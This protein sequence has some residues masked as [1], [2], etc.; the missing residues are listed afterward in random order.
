MFGKKDGGN[1]MNTAEI[2]RMSKKDRIIL[3]EKLW[4]T[5][6]NDQDEPGSPEWHKP[7]LDDRRQMIESGKA[8]FISIDDLRA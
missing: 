7:I 4:N 8:K 1:G 6:V 5:F 3:M 2:E